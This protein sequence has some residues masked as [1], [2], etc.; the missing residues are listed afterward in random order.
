MEENPVQI[1]SGATQIG[2]SIYLLVPSSFAKVFKIENGQK[3]I[4]KKEG[5]SIIFTYQ[6]EEKDDDKL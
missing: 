6:K 3:F 2:G 5:N 4:V 1:E